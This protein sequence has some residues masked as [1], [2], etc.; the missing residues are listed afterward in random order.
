MSNLTRE[1]VIRDM[2]EA[3]E[4]MGLELEDLQEMIIDVIDDCLSKSK[5]LVQAVRDKGAEEIKRIAHDIKGATAN[6]GLLNPSKLAQKLEKS[7]DDPSLSIAEE[8]A[9]DFELLKTFKLD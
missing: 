5:L 3:A 7:C 4:R 8:L 1:N 9:A 6:Y 2:E